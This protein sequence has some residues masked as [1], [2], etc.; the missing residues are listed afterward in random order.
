MNT[1][2]LLADDEALFRVL[3]Q[4]ALSR[5]PARIVEACD[6]SAA[7]EVI[8]RETAPVL[9]VLDWQMPGLTGVQLCERIRSL[10]PSRL[11]YT[12]LVT[13]RTGRE[14]ILTGLASGANDYITKPFDNEELLARVQVGLR[15]LGLQQALADRVAEL[16][17]AL[18][19]IKQLQGLL[20]ICS[21]CK[22]IRTDKDYWQKV[23]HYLSDHADVRFSHGICPQCYTTIVEP[24]LNAFK[25]RL[26]MTMNSER[27]PSTH[28]C[29]EKEAT[30]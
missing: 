19:R 8:E 13:G 2:I 10:P 15:V 26:D 16:E 3:L 29:D 11:V 30:P 1:T 28:D 9:A 18:T 24:Q 6:G 4:G 5:L 27:R 21:Y 7:W 23:E 22:S 14:A 25:Q 12:I 20:P 17:T